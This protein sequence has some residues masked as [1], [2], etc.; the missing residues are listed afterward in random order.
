MQRFK[1]TPTEINNVLKLIHKYDKI[2][3]LKEKNKNHVIISV[4]SEKN[5]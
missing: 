2:F 1:L 4:A 3:T 5:I